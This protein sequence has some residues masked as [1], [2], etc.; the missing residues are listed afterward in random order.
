ML[1]WA[2]DTPSPSSSSSSKLLNSPTV[3]FSLLPPLSTRRHESRWSGSEKERDYIAMRVVWASASFVGVETCVV[4]GSTVNKRCT[5]FICRRPSGLC[6]R[7]PYTNSS[8][9]CMRVRIGKLCT[10]ASCASNS[11]RKMTHIACARPVYPA[12]RAQFCWCQL[13]FFTLPMWVLDPFHIHRGDLLELVLCSAAWLLLFSLRDGGHI[14]DTTVTLWPQKA[15]PWRGRRDPGVSLRTSPMEAYKI[16]PY[17][18][19]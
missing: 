10:R 6:W 19:L 17:F 8:K 4:G 9:H 11:A 3:L 14:G 13:L 7:Q 5:F 16:N 15:Y 2:A 12:S 18:S 1:H